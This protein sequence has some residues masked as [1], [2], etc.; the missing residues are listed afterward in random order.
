MQNVVFWIRYGSKAEGIGSIPVMKVNV[1]KESK[2]DRNMET[3]RQNI[4]RYGIVHDR[5][6]SSSFRSRICHASWPRSPR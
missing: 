1:Q 4:G 3:I 5:M 2:Y 6:C